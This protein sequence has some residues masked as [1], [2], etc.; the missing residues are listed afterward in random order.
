MNCVFCVF[1]AMLLPVQGE[2]IELDFTRISQPAV[3][4]QLELSDE[5]RAKIAGLLTDRIQKLAAAKSADRAAIRQAN[6][7]ALKALLSPTQLQKY[8]TLLSGGKLRFNFSGEKW[9]DVLNWFA[10]E[11]GLSLVMNQTIPGE[12][13]YAD[14]KEY[15]GPQ[16]IDLL[17][18]I[19]L[20]KGYTLIRRE[21]MLIVANLTDGIPYELV[22][23]ESL[24]GLAK[25]G[26]FEWV[27]IKFPLGGRPVAAVLEE[28]KPMISEHGQATALAASGQLMVTETAGKMEA[29]GVL[30]S[31]V[32]VP[33]S[34]PPPKPQPAPVPSVF[35]VHSA[36]GL[37]IDGTVETLKK[38]FSTTAVVGDSLAEE[39]QVYAPQSTQDLIKSSLDQMIKVASTDLKSYTEIYPIE[40]AS[41]ANVQEQLANLFADTT[42]SI[43]GENSR[44]IVSANARVHRGIQ[45][46]L[47]KLGAAS[48]APTN[49]Q[50]V[51]YS[52][53]ENEADNLAT[54]L[55]E[56][57]PRAQVIVQGNRI[58]VRGK[59]SDHKVAKSL[60]DQI[61]KDPSS[62]NAI[63]LRFYE[64]NDQGAEITS[65]LQS[66]AK[67]G[68]VTWLES[69]QKF[70]V[71]ADAE[72]QALVQK[73][74]EQI[75]SDLPKQSKKSLRIFS[76][77]PFQKEKFSDVFASLSTQFGDASIIS[78]AGP[79]ELAILGNAEQQAAI[80]SV[81]Q[82]IAGL[83]PSGEKE[84]ISIP[85]TV[86]DADQLVKLLENQVPNQEFLVNPQND[87]LF[88][89]TEKANIEALRKTVSSIEAVLPKKSLPSLEVYEIKSS[90]AAVE[91]FLTPVAGEAKITPDEVNK[92]LV[93]W[94][95]ENEHA[96]IKA[97]IEKVDVVTKATKALEVYE[98]KKGTASLAQTMISNL[99]VEAQITESNDSRSLLIWATAEDHEK[100]KAVIDQLAGI[101]ATS[102]SKVELF[103]VQREGAAKTLAAV[104]AVF[105]EANVSLDSTSK[106]I[107]SI[108][109][110]DLQTQ[111]KSLI[112]KL[113]PDTPTSPQ[114]LM[115]YELKNSDAPTVV[116]MLIDLHPDI[117]FAADERANRVLVTAELAEQPRFKAMIN[118]LDAKATDRD[119][120]VLQTYDLKNTQV[121]LV[122]EL[123]EPLLPEMK[124]S[125]DQANQKL[126]VLGTSFEHQKL[127]KLLEQARN[128]ANAKKVLKYYETGTAPV[129]EVRNVLL[130]VVPTATIAINASQGKIVV[131]ATAEE[132]ALIKSAVQQ[133]NLVTDEELTL[134]SFDLERQVSTDTVSFMKTLSRTA[135]VSASYDG[136][137]IV[138]MGTAADIEMFKSIVTELN[139]TGTNNQRLKAYEA[140]A[141]V[142]T[143]A[144]SVITSSF[145]KA[146]LVPQP[147]G[148][149]LI[150]W[151]TEADHV[152]IEQAVNDLK[153]QLTKERTS[154]TTTIYLLGKVTKATAVEMISSEEL[155]VAILA[156]NQTD[157]LIVRADEASH[158]KVTQVIADLKKTFEV[159]EEKVIKS[160][161]VRQDIKAQATTT[162]TSL[163][164][165]VEF[166]PNDNDSLILAKASPADHKALSQL[167]KTLDTEIAKKEPRT[168]AAY[169]LMDLDKN[170]ATE[171][172]VNRFPDVDIVP[173][174]ST[175][176][177]LIW[178]VKSQHD[179]VPDIL[180]GLEATVAVEKDLVVEVYNIDPKKMQATDVW[181]LIDS[182][183]KDNVTLQVS[184]ETNSLIVRASAQRHAS[185]RKEIETVVNKIAIVP[186]PSTRVYEFPAGNAASVSALVS[187]LLTNTTLSVSP[188]GKKLAATSR[189]DGHELIQSVIDQLQ[190]D[191]AKKD[192]E[193][194][195]YKL[196]A[197]IP[198]VVT[199][200]V[201]AMSPQAKITADDRSM[202]LIISA[203]SKEHQVI[204]N[205]LKQINDS[206]LGKKTEVFTLATA[207]PAAMVNAISALVSGA[208][209][210][211]DEA[212]NSVV[213]TALA[214]DFVQIQAIVDKLDLAAA[215]QKDLVAR[216]YPFDKELVDANDMVAALDEDLREG[217]Y[218]RINE[219]GNGLIV[220]ATEAK[221]VLIKQLFDQLLE[222]LPEKSRVETR[223]YP[224]QKLTPSV[225]DDVLSAKYPASSFAVD[226]NTRTLVATVTVG[227]HDKIK[228][229]LDQ[230]AKQ[231]IRENVASKAFKL[232]TATPRAVAGAITSLLPDAKVTF[233]IASDTV[234][235]TGIPSEIESASELVKQIDGTD[236]GK[237][238]RVYKLVEAD[239]RFVSP[240]IEQ[241][242]P[243][244]TISADRYSK[245]LF[246][247]ASDEEHQQVAKMVEELNSKQGQRSEV[248]R[249]TVA[250]PRYVMPAVQA[251]LPSATVTADRYSKSLFVTGTDEDH[252]EVAKLIEKMNGKI[253]GTRS[254]VYKLIEADPR[255]VSPAIEALLPNATVSGDRYSKT[256][257]V[258]GTDEDHKQV[259]ALIEKLNG[260][261]TG[262]TTEV[263][264]LDKASSLILQPALAA[265]VP[266]GKVT[267]DRVS[268]TIVVS[269]TKED[270][271]KVASVIEKLDKAT[272]DEKVLRIYKSKFDNIDPVNRTIEN[273]FR[274]DKEVRMNFDWDNRRIMVVATEAKH[275]LIQSLVDQVDQAKPKQEDRFAKVYHLEN[276]ES[277]AA[278][279]V[280]RNL[281][282]WWIPRL[283]IRRE[284]GINALIVVATAKQHE[285]LAPSIQNV[286]G[287]LRKLEVFALANVDPYT[288]ELAIEQLF[289]EIP[290]NMRP[291]ATSDF[292]TQQLFVRGSAAQIKLIRD[293]LNK[294][295]ESFDDSTQPVS[296]GGVRTIPFRG[297]A[298][299]ALREIEEFWPRIRRNKIEI[300]RPGKTKI[301]REITPRKTGEA[302][303]GNFEIESDKLSPIGPDCGDEWPEGQ[304]DGEISD[305]GIVDS[306]LQ[307]DEPGIKIETLNPVQKN[308][309]PAGQDSQEIKD[310]QAQIVV[311]PGENEI[312]IASSDLEALDQLEYL[313]RTIQRGARGGM[314]S[315][316]FAVYLLSNSS[317][318][319]TAKLLSELFEAI[320]STERQGSVG[321]AIFVADERLNAMVV[322]GT[323]KERDVIQEII[324]VLDAEDL[325]DSLTT[326]VPELIQIQNSSADRVLRIL[327]SVYSNQLSSGGGRRKLEIPEGV[328]TAVA[329]MLQQINAATA[330]PILTLGVDEKTNSIVM[331]APLEL[332]REIK[333]FVERLESTAKKSAAKNVRIYRV[334]GTNATR[335]R[336]IIRGMANE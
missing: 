165:S 156:D 106:K 105:P 71:I 127:A 247:T 203:T 228:S 6:N 222:Q 123:I 201:S 312:T 173:D 141:E 245:A 112:E 251:L 113:Q 233:D 52:V 17:N 78:G 330:G 41:I 153:K 16:A 217:T 75:N 61:A 219:V 81:L 301:Q 299:D 79:K 68:I 211:A 138:V 264:K 275:E 309:E 150:V 252:I 290:E 114:V 164:P 292:G 101:K 225:I 204:A 192:Q 318:K 243:N 256:L 32:P 335:V 253:E 54:V 80:E 110:D 160:H 287:D 206:T 244:A 280:I 24:E 132:Q 302:N 131:W 238:T 260:R 82:S 263:Y 261:G 144:N 187:P 291:S 250:D 121:E 128:Q 215:A 99:E 221:H 193:T 177:L 214:T 268:N 109:D 259:Q 21:K 103:P 2:D 172:L 237:T 89:W 163:L 120:K 305:D 316:N 241:L 3:A 56:M 278:E 298:M 194:V 232:K 90:V 118:Q 269:A 67:D 323:R 174:T 115:S 319:D 334:E 26:K 325:P 307:E 220:R 46:T 155:D 235:V 30:V 230:M 58:A 297:N 34:P 213:V 20:S 15:T 168:V 284:Q 18:S 185:L 306:K 310:D 76:V 320:P 178:A 161:A 142:V 158:Q 212:T 218:V 191:S 157:R 83:E 167:I 148:S 246:V 119:E 295:G 126:V 108:A 64:I 125:I 182:K 281:Y 92:R 134:K 14:Q 208:S 147:D 239:P 100:I 240:A 293:M 267:A 53:P 135:N 255:Y 37:D 72:T 143:S 184:T 33:T 57:L 47:D 254:E 179:L 207:K 231:A 195:V 154:K 171:I 236:Q 36:K 190:L 322:Y 313:I 7:N 74:I 279:G 326:P 205:I 69:R 242:L 175:S 146:R 27:R 277:Q 249:L 62:Q 196:N 162:I 329:S 331:R 86:E 104:Q 77:T 31:A 140:S 35:V 88:A 39:I 48:T 1:C 311:I 294:M 8:Q 308:P 60:I 169:K 209:V 73:T 107:I 5:Q 116:A 270:Q 94:A 38:F 133:L 45:E 49:I 51:I 159:V 304:L 273:M 285:E 91:P 10:R 28:V 117:R 98:M 129:D 42:F 274:E 314:G 136:M 229:I 282:G 122:T 25:R 102:Q 84:L 324:E 59:D 198:S 181:E 271:A 333:S 265:L 152:K 130:Q 145:P 258:T 303:P 12:F 199:T 22:P 202:S 66:I 234:I 276:I 315:S 55:T 111:I 149:K 23:S 300:I 186:S 19:L 327:S 93:I 266:D 197:A 317:A 332:G 288:V 289:A 189:V 97:T 65:T 216:V 210:T 9:E 43:D 272:S 188:D 151:A 176:R 11:S 4:S 262:Q 248:Y 283:D 29:I 13:T 226:A 137:Q 70:S 87:S 95:T 180:K 96:R 328:T 296:N 166:L 40:D 321:N 227:E 224:L 124:F 85:V 257:F 223:V 139:Q 50:V 170:L 200:A 44:L 336:E 286:D 63:Q 183:L